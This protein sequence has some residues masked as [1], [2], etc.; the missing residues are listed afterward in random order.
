MTQRA[1]T[2]TVEAFKV[3]GTVYLDGGIYGDGSGLTG[4]SAASIA[5]DSLD[6]DKFVEFHCAC[7]RKRGIGDHTFQ[8]VHY[9]REK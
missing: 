3:K 5:A 8:A 9:G 4:I 2:G 7:P 1:P 6:F